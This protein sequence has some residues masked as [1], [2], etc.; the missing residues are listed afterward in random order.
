MATVTILQGNQ[1]LIFLIETCWRGWPR[2]DV[3]GCLSEILL[4]EITLCCWWL[5]LPIQNS[6]KKAEKWPKP[7]LVVFIWEYSARANQWIPTWQGLDGYQKSLHPCAFDKNSLSIS[8]VKAWLRLI[9][10][11]F[12]FSLLPYHSYK[13]VQ[14]SWLGSGHIL[15]LEG[16][17]VIQIFHTLHLGYLVVINEYSEVAGLVKCGKLSHSVSCPFT[18]NILLECC[19]ALWNLNWLPYEKLRK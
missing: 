1:A 3:L 19:K 18:G 16:P 8:K 10:A 4:K 12:Y 14:V 7:W 11:E 6:A 17:T 2:W 9:T 15:I 5:I 13:L